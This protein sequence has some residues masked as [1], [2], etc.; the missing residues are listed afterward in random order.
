VCAHPYTGIGDLTQN[1]VE[2]RAVEALLDRVYPDEYAVEVEQL[3]SHRL[4]VS[5]E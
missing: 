5:S 1:G 2:L 4:P 3:I